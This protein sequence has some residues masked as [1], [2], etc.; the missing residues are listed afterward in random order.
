LLGGAIRWRLTLK[1]QGN[2]KTSA[3]GCARV[4]REKEGGVGLEVD[5]VLLCL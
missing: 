1:H 3:S 4:V 5:R 2:P